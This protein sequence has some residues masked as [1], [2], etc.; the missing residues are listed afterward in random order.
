MFCRTFAWTH[1]HCDTLSELSLQL[2]KHI[3]LHARNAVWELVL[4]TRSQWKIWIGLERRL[5]LSDIF[6]VHYPDPHGLGVWRRNTVIIYVNYD[7]CANNLMSQSHYEE[8]FRLLMPFRWKQM[9]VF[10]YA[11]SRWPHWSCCVSQ[12]FCHLMETIWNLCV[13]NLQP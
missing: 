6:N 3:R 13:Q 2:R 12:A 4:G 8:G 10:L 7:Y 11:A 1:T 5:L 9:F